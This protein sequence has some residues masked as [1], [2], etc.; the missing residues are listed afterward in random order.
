MIVAT[1]PGGASFYSNDGQLFSDGDVTI[2]SPA[3]LP[4]DTELSSTKPGVWISPEGGSIRAQVVD[5]DSGSVLWDRD[6]LSLDEAFEMVRDA[7]DRLTA[8]LH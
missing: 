3:F 7:V 8:E 6:G 2:Y 1:P 4:D 5:I